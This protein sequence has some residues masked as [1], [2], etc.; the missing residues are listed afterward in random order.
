MLTLILLPLT[1]FPEQG[2]K[3]VLNA[4]VPEAEFYL[5]ANFVAATDTNGTLIME[6]F[7]AGSFSLS[8]VK[9]G[10]KTYTGSFSISEGEHKVLSPIMERI[11]HAGKPSAMAAENLPDTRPL[12]PRSHIE[13]KAASAAEEIQLP[14]TQTASADVRSPD[15]PAGQA[16]EKESLPFSRSLVLIISFAAISLA[17]VILIMKRKRRDAQIPPLDINR[18]MEDP[19]PPN[20]IPNRPEP[21]FIGELRRREELLNAGFVGNKPRIPDQ[22]S[23]REK[24]VVIVLPKEAFRFEDDK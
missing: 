8:I 20:D 16:P 21:E 7:P 1:S 22:E 18:A 24:E 11:G 9:K 17:A 2:G 5:D 15:Q 6:N 13:P 4:G 12:V 19:N 3:V 14:P 10:Y 23:M